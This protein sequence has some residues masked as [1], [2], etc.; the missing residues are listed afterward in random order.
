MPQYQ[1]LAHIFWELPFPLRLPPAAFFCW[2]PGEGLGLFDPQPEVGELVWKRRSCLLQAGEVF[3]DVGHPSQCY[4]EHDYLITSR[5][6]TG[7]EIKTAQLRRGPEGGFAEA[8]PY[9]IANI[10][11]CLRLRSDYSSPAVLERAGLALNNILDV[12]RFITMDPLA[13]SVRADQ[14]CYYTLVSVAD[15]PGDLG[16]VEPRTALQLLGRLS[17]GS[18]IGVNRAHHVGLNSFDDLIAGDTIANDALRVFDTL[19]AGTHTLELFHQLVFSAI[20]RLKRKE[21]ALSVLDAQSA[22]ESL[23]AVLVAESLTAQGEAL[24]QVEAAMVPG[25]RIHTLQHRLEKLDR[26]AATQTGPGAQPRRFLGS[27][28]ESQWRIALY[29]LRNRIV[30]EGLRDV[31]FAEAKAGL[32]AGLHAIYRV[33]QLTPSFNRAMIWSEHTL[34]LGHLQ[35]SAGRISRLFEA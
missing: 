23:V 12:Y 21:H 6:R 13:R 34:D 2:E 4:P 18:K 19:I 9:S 25:G 14:D 20:R 22:F 35:Q 27:P 7:R 33:Q 16:D 15:L 3:A 11:L 5:L 10:F 17:F 8:R 31:P 24:Q 1:A 28:E 32:V 26:V 30:H 29:A